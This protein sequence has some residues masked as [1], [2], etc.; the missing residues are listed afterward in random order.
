MDM[1]TTSQPR[2][3]ELLS[4]LATIATVKA[5]SIGLMRKDKRASIEADKAHL[6]MIGAGVNNVNRLAGAEAR[7]KEIRSVQ[8]QG[9]DVLMRFT[10]QWG[11]RRLLPNVNINQ[12][13]AEWGVVKAEFDRLCVRIA[14]D[15]PI[16][17]RQAEQNLGT[18][19]IEPPT[20]DEL[21]N[22]FSLEFT[23][24]QVPD[25][26]QFKASGLDAS[27]EQLLKDRFEANIESAYQ[28]AQSDALA[29]LARPLETLIERM[30]AYNKREDEK[31]KGISVGK[32]GF[33]RDTIITN[34]TEIAQVFGSFNL[35]NDPGLKRIED[36]LGAFE[37]IEA[38][39]LRNS[40]DLRDDTA[41]RAEE[42][43]AALGIERTQ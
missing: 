26:S 40:K 7:V 29:R 43:L 39:D 30:G 37:G 28:Q 1:T 15:A 31:A 11:D 9:R 22:G 17:I 3:S 41:K 36:A 4:Q 19:A 42:I 10:T 32:D 18:Y 25:S 34:I 21:K 6:A 23:M 13:Y 12:F 35:T 38:D 27:M 5:T 8:A 20:E 2:M 16:L 24:E 33:F 14:A